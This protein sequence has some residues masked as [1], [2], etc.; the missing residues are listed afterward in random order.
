MFQYFPFDVDHFSM[1]MGTR[2]LGKGFVIEVDP[3]CYHA[4]ITLKQR[5]LNDDTSY[6]FQALPHTE[7]LQWDTLTYLLPHL[8]ACYPQHFSLTMQ[9]EHWIWHNHLLQECVTFQPGVHASLPLSPLDW[10]GRQLQEDLLL[11]DGSVDGGIPLVAGQLC[12]P[13]SW[14]LEEKLGQSFL[15]IHDPVALFAE[16]LGRS[17][18]LLLERLKVGRP[19]WRLN[20]AFRTIDRLDITPR[21]AHEIQQSYQTLTPETIGER[22]LLR[23]ERQTL[24]RLPTT[25][26]ILFTVHTYQESVAE[27]THNVKHARRMASVLRSTP[28]EVLAYKGIAPFADLLLDYLQLRSH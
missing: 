5:L 25:G 16:Q 24:S 28:A 15:H 14:C 27:L 6:Y 8:A 20:W 3:A 22:C 9:T 26:A 17:S 19:V 21:T 23:V 13:N 18:Q 4:E 1:T 11:L 10:L 7:P 12:F 2:A